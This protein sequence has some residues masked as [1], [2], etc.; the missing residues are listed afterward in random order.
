MCRVSRND[1][2]V[3]KG[4]F[5]TLRYLVTEFTPTYIIRLIAKVLSG[6]SVKVRAPKNELFTRYYSFINRNL[7]R[8]KEKIRITFV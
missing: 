4:A 2:D 6:N 5:Y 8:Q 3:H 1:I 7:N